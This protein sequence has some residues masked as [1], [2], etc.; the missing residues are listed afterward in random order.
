MN[1]SLLINVQPQRGVTLF[2]T[3]E[4]AEILTAV[5]AVCLIAL[6]IAVIAKM[7]K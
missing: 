1:K 6:T 2:A 5:V 3:N 7:L 4:T